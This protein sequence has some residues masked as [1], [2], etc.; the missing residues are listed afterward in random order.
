MGL[1]FVALLGVVLLGVPGSP[2][3]QKPTLGLDLQGGTEVVLKAIPPKGQKVTSDGM[4]TARS[5]MDRRVNKLGVTEPEIRK[6]GSDQ[7]V[8]E[9][10]G[11]DPKRATELIGKTAKLELYDLQGDLAPQTSI[12]DLLVTLQ[13]QAKKGS[14]DQFYLLKPV[15]K[16]GAKK[17][18]Y[19]LAVGPMSTRAAVLKSKYV[20]THGKKGQL[21]K[22]HRL[23]AVPENMVVVTCGKG[24]RFCP[25]LPNKPE[26]T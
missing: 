24:D 19:E 13:R 12:F 17:P 9:L 20:R 5:V 18:E 14:A 2:L 11:V 7:M 15:E 21:P 6:Q 1:I 16:A 25:N 3:H 23:F 22:G 10:A 4:D 8:I 26:R